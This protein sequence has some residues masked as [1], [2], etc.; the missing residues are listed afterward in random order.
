[1]KKFIVMSLVLAV[2]TAGVA[3]PSAHA[4]SLSDTLNNVSDKVEGAVQ[5]VESDIKARLQQFEQKRQ[6][7][8][9]NKRQEIENRVAEK[10][11][12]IAEKL[13]GERKLRCESREAGINQLLDNRT[14][15]AQRH[16]DTFKSI[17]DR[18]TTF[19]ANKNINVEN[20]AALEL[21][22]N[23]AQTAA[24]AAITAVGGVD[25][26]CKDADASSPGHIVM[27]EVVAAKE[28]LKEYRQAIR[29]YAVAVRAAVT[30]ETE[31]PEGAAQ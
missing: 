21:I 7:E 1:M 25:F 30:V 11:A 22:M 6:D 2:V 10:R 18:L 17:Q 24:Q 3:A 12:A 23:D 28:A 16:F 27:D 19:V 4:V 14:A 29:D 9:Q 15:A 26:V 31:T 20:A 13:S 5:G 8:I